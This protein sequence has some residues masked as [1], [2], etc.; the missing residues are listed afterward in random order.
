MSWTTEVDRHQCMGSGICVGIAPH[1]YRLKDYRAEPVRREIDP[2]ES[3]L[4]AAE[5]CPALAILV[6]DGDRVVGPQP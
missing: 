6:R 3:A 5:V 2:D 1:L 4:E